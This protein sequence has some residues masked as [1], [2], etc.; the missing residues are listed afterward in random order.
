MSLESLPLLGLTAA[1]GDPALE[2]SFS[3]THCGADGALV[4]TAWLGAQADRMVARGQGCFWAPLAFG[5]ELY[6]VR[7]A[8]RNVAFNRSVWEAVEVR[9]EGDPAPLSQDAAWLPS[10][11]PNLRS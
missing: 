1:A 5:A 2:V 4:L 6:W 7:F 3:V 8:K 11:R 9:P 10:T